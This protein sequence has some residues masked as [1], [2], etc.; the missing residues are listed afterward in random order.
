MVEV[1]ELEARIRSAIPEVETLEI[2]DLTGTRDHFEATIVSASFR[3]KSRIAQ[4]QMVYRALGE[5]MAGAVHALALQTLTP[6]AWAEANE[7]NDV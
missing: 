1:S 5:L 2:R 3:G 7:E 6:E 4:H